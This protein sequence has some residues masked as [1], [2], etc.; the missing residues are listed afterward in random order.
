MPLLGRRRVSR[1]RVTA[2]LP[3]A[4]VNMA[5]GHEIDWHPVSVANCHIH[6]SA[7]FRDRL[8]RVR[9]A[10]GHIHRSALLRDRLARVR[11]AEGHIH[12]SLGQAQRR[13]R[14]PIPQTYARC[15][16]AIPAPHGEVALQA[17]GSFW[18]APTWGDA[19]CPAARDTR[20]PQATVNMAFGHEIDSHRFR[21]PITTFAVARYC[22]IDSHEFPW[23][24]TTFI[25]ARFCEIGWHEFVWPKATF[26]VAWGKRSVAPG[27]PSRKHTHAVGVPYRRRMV[28]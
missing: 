11:V 27:R 5:F 10:E 23:S 21:W 17:T 3:Q 15:R 1:W 12:R 6:R 14:T 4:T 28:R 22:E 18:G 8:A 25:V 20:L 19:A 9:V 7:F 16:R 13:P 24:I 2:R 26:T